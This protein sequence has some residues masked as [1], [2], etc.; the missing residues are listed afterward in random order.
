MHYENFIKNIIPKSDFKLP[1]CQL[2]A[3]YNLY[4]LDGNILPGWIQ[5]VGRKEAGKER[6]DE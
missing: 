1:F 3:K 6:S 4:F 5:N 2:S